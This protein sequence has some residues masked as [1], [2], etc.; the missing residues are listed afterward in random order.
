MPQVGVDP[1]RAELTSW[2]FVAFASGV[3]RPWLLT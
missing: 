3:C 2:I 1:E